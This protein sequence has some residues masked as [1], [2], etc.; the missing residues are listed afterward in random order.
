MAS[1]VLRLATRKRAEEKL[2]NLRRNGQGNL[3][4]GQQLNNIDSILNHL[5]GV[6]NLTAP[7][8]NI[9]SN[10]L[11]INNDILKSLNCYRRCLCHCRTCKRGG[12][13]HMLES[14]LT[15]GQLQALGNVTNNPVSNG[16]RPLLHINPYTNSAIFPGDVSTRDPFTARAP[17]PS[18]L[19]TLAS[20]RQQ[21]R[22]LDD[23]FVII[24][25]GLFLLIAVGVWQDF[26][27]VFYDQAFPGQHNNLYIRLLFVVTITVTMIVIIFLVIRW[28]DV[29]AM[30]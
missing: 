2:A 3:P 21:D 13:S 12:E 28:L 25:L 17:F 22:L 20:Q 18:S 19:T 9:G 26:F 11:T 4:E 16:G 15:S 23:E 1:T 6:D 14:L 24:T 5:N 27:R 7:N 8:G 10:A 29:R 30:E